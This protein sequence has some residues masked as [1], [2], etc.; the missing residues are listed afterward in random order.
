LKWA[1]KDHYHHS[2]WYVQ[3]YVIPTAVQ[4]KVVISTVAMFNKVI[5]YLTLY[6]DIFKKFNNIVVS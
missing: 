6:F 4:L 1:K 2:R 5:Y 3:K